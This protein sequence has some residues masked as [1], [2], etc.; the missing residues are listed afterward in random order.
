MNLHEIL[1]PGD[2]VYTNVLSVARSGMSRT[3]KCYM[4]REGEMSD[5]TY[6]VAQ[7]TGYSIAKNG[8]IRIG[9]CGMDMGFALVYELS[10]KL[11][12]TD[13][14]SFKEQ[15]GGYALNQRWL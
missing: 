6:P 14:E 15:T 13:Q 5:I 4:V 12:P 11:F 1:K 10:R 3:I 8:G 7:I 9:G 2:T